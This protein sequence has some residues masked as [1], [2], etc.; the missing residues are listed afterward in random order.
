MKYQGVGR[1]TSSPSAQR[2]AIAAAIALPAP[3]PAHTERLQYAAER[4]GNALRFARRQSRHSSA[5]YGV[6]VD[7]AAGRVRVFA[8]ERVLEALKAKE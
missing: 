6:E 3:A 4:V 2:V 8:P 1:I 5:E 7:A